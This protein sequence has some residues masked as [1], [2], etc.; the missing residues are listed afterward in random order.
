MSGTVGVICDLAARYS[1]FT[2]CLARMHSPAN[3]AVE[4]GKGADR[5]VN[6][7]HVVRQALSYGSEWVL[8]LDDDHSFPPTLLTRLL[9]HGQPVVASLYLRRAAPFHPI[10]YGARDETGAY[11][12]VDLT[13]CGPAELVPVVGAGTGG[14]LIRSE[15]FRAL[16]DPWFVHTTEKSEDLSFCEK[17]LEVGF[18][19]FVDTGARLGH[20]APAE[21]FPAF[22]N[23]QWCAGLNFAAST[24][25]LLPLDLGATP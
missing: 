2:E 4:F 9:S 11:L 7:N 20:I 22:E 10:A 8:F 5:S 17:A 18:P 14:M 12:P 23:G 6:R 13:G 24:R 15:V 3:T 21:T 25:V 19:L 16:E 1:S